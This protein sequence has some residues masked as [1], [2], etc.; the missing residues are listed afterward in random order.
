MK[1]MSLPR[2]PGPAALGAFSV[3]EQLVGVGVIAVAITS[4]Y[5]SFSSG[6]AVIQLAR[7]N[8][9]A[10][11]VL[12]E[13]VE[14]LRLYTFD[15]LTSPGYVPTNFTAPFYPSGTNNGGFSYS[16]TVSISNPPF[17][18]NYSNDL[19]L[20]T[21]EVTWTSANVLRRRS[22]STLVARN[23]LQAYVY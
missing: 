2:R 5:A 10:T 14:V 15:Q 7:E 17:S 19:K 1:L 21:F 8:L 4:V 23:G 12:Q 18:V 11:Q 3:V 6:F 13:K 22:M 20:V 16:G 9:R